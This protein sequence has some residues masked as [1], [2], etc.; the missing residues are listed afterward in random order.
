MDSTWFVTSARRWASWNKDASESSVLHIKCS[1]FKLFFV[2][3]LFSSRCS[4]SLI[5]NEFLS[6]STT[7]SPNLNPHGL[8]NRKWCWLRAGQLT[9]ET[10]DVL[11]LIFIALSSRRCVSVWFTPRCL[12]IVRSLFGDEPVK[13]WNPQDINSELFPHMLRTGAWWEGWGLWL[14]DTQSIIVHDWIMFI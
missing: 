7:S 1:Y 11:L 5:Q 4:D 2:T 9:A 10:E 6:S 14:N 8:R 3:L 13:V 12:I